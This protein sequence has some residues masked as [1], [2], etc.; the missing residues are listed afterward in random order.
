VPLTANLFLV[1]LRLHEIA[2]PIKLSLSEKEKNIHREARK[3]THSSHG[4]LIN[5]AE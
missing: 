1:T 4:K 2:E 3:K 5:I